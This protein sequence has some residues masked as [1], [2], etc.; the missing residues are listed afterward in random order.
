MVAIERLLL[1][2]PDLLKDWG[3]LG[4]A[5]GRGR[6]LLLLLEEDE[7]EYWLGEGWW[8]WWRRREKSGPKARTLAEMRPKFCSRLEVENVRQASWV[9][10]DGGQ[11]WRVRT[12]WAIKLR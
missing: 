12:Y 5:P 10:L 6:L 7:E 11:N 4:F 8:W 3:T 1:L 9:S 2:L